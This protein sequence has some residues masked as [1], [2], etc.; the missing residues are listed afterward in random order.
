MSVPD[1]GV[2][3][4]LAAMDRLARELFSASG[5]LGEHSLGLSRHLTAAGVSTEPA[6]RVGEAASWCYERSL[7]VQRRANAAAAEAGSPIA[8]TI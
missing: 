1:D 6:R 8:P 2:A 4:D 3:F 5:Q 7:Q